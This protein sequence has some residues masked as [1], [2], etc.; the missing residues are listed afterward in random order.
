MY[1]NNSEMF[2]GVRNKNFLPV[3]QSFGSSPLAIWE[4]KVIV[5][6][7]ATSNEKSN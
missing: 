1:H 3:F 6:K 7:G 5:P 4:K 2:H